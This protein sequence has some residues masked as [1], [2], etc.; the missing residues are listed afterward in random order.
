MGVRCWAWLEGAWV[1]LLARAVSIARCLG[2]VRAVQLRKLLEE[3]VKPT[4]TISRNCAFMPI[5]AI[6]ATRHPRDRPPPDSASTCS[7][8]PLLLIA[9]SSAKAAICR[10]QAVGSR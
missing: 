6:A 7:S 5:A 2:T 4:S 8:Q 9:T 1:S 10:T 3:N